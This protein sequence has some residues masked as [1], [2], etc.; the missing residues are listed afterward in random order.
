VS[1]PTSS[2]ADSSAISNL[3]NQMSA[4]GA[5]QTAE[6][7]QLF[8]LALPGLTQAESYY[9]KLASGSP[10][11]LATANAPAIAGITQANNSA[12]QSITQ[13][14]PRGGQTNLA[15]ENADLSKG[16]QIG[17]LTTQSYTNAFPS[18]AQLGGQNVAQGTGAQA[19]GVSSMGAAANQYQGLLQNNAA[20]KSSTMGFL[21]SL[22]GGGAELGSAALLA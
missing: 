1:K 7:S 4:T 19:A 8:N 3:A 12:K 15:L 6:G 20:S 16:A 2:A 10:Q 11:A 22:A 13:D 18:L 17:N 9:G 14:N 5:A 21:G